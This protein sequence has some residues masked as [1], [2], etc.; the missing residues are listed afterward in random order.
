MYIIII[1]IFTSNLSCWYSMKICIIVPMYNEADRFDKKA[2]LEYTQLH[3]IHFL[4][5]DDGS[6]DNTQRIIVELSNDNELISSISLSKNKG[7][8]EAIRTAVLQLT[9]AKTFDY[10]GY[11]DADF[12]T[13][14]GEIQ[15]FIETI[16]KT[17]K[18]FVMGIRLKRIGAEIRRYKLRHYFGRI[19]AS[20]ISEFILGLPVYDT[21]CGAKMI[22]TNLALQLFKESF[23]SKWFFDVELIARMKQIH[24]KE[25]CR[26]NILELPL[27]TWIDKGHSKISF[28][29]LIKTPFILLKLMFKYR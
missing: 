26:K 5:V 21:Q 22:E 16:N 11:F 6:K 9:S 28:F 14:L 17:Y 12:A 15:H 19:I 8:A 27:N 23:H 18:P 25:Y 3:D 7:K 29:D 24:G 2:L 10:I 4:L 1:P 13:P 20:V